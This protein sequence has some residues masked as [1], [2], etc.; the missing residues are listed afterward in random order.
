MAMTLNPVKGITV[1]GMATAWPEDLL[2]PAA[3][4]HDADVYAS[5]LG[6]SWR[7]YLTERQWDFER[8]W[9]EFGVRRRGWTRGTAVGSLELG[10][11]AGK[12]AL[13]DA[14]IKASDVDC[15]VAAT[16]SPNHIT[17]TI[18]GKLAKHL[19][20][21]AAAIDIRA[22]GA[23]GLNALVTA[24]LYHTAG[25][26][27]SLVIAAEVSSKY[28][29]D[30]DLSNALLFGD[31]AAALVLVSDPNGG[32]AGLVGAVIGNSDWQGSAFTVPGVL[33]PPENYSVEDYRFQRPD[34]IY[35]ENLARC[36]DETGKAL[37]DAFPRE[38]P[39][40]NAVLPYAVTRDQVVQCVEQFGVSGED[41]I[42]LLAEHGCIGCASPLAAMVLH[43]QRRRSNGGDIADETIASL[44]VAGGISW[45]GLLWR[46]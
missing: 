46:I 29:G 23:G 6:D 38:Q 45:T 11:A 40:L 4:M 3:E 42:A 17:S 25:C 28:L 24:A 43:W 2:G 30:H 35:R 10:I 9:K 7:E 31:G 16:C 15:I 44:A 14:G 5:I 39:D 18:A 34:A 20:T 21:T 41:S 1:T 32:E 12:K 22:G 19:K 36:W 33:P 8:S 26:K 27:V 13:A 37:R